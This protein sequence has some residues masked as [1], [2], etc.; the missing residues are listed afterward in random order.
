VCRAPL[1]VTTRDARFA[2]AAGVPDQLTR[3]LS[4]SSL[5]EVAWVDADGT[6]G[7]AGVLPL[8][9]DGVALLALTL[10]RAELAT[11]LAAAD[12]VDLLVRKPRNATAGWA[13]AAW[14]CRSRLVEDLGGQ[15]LRD[16]LLLQ[17]LRRYPVARRYADSPLL[18]RE[19]WWYLPRLVVELTPETSLDAPPVRSG[20]GDLLLVTVADGRPVAGGVRADP[21]GLT[22]SWG[23]SPSPGT[24]T[25]LGQD[26]SFPDLEVWRTWQRAVTVSDGE[27]VAREPI[28]TLGPGRTPGLWQRWRAERDFAAACRRGIA[29]W[30]G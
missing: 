19:H 30:Q 26:A 17:E 8:V 11:A 12:A 27:V 10:D 20:P 18:S 28:P 9:R 23:P 4:S 5:G 21:A 1:P 13:P 16:D 14:R 29:A 15:L 22:P 24:G 3:L 25:V 2:Y 6:P 7:A